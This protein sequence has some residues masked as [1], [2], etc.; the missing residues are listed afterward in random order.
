[1]PEP[2]S[3]ASLGDL[4]PSEYAGKY[5]VFAVLHLDSGD[6]RF[7]SFRTSAGGRWDAVNGWTQRP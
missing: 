3:V 7:N 2:V 6:L 4:A 1:M 5:P